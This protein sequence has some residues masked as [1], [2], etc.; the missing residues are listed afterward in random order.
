[1]IETERLAFMTNEDFLEEIRQRTNAIKDLSND[2]E[3]L[4]S[5]WLKQKN[6]TPE[7]VAQFLR[8]AVTQIPLDLPSYPVG[9]KRLYPMSGLLSWV[10]SHTKSRKAEKDIWDKE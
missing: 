8:C 6:L 7:E 5:A 3:I 9:R 4:T 1:M 2:I 10:K